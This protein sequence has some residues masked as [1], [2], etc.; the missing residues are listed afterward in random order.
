MPCEMNEDCISLFGTGT[1]DLT[2]NRCVGIRK[3]MELG[4]LQCL[5]DHMN[6]VT[7]SSFFTGI[8]ATLRLEHRNTSILTAEFLRDYL[9]HEECVSDYGPMSPLREHYTALSLLPPEGQL[10]PSVCVSFL[11]DIRDFATSD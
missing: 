9:K 3:E 10:C 1:C 7:K 4:F 11:A 2:K 8:T 6:A 5:L